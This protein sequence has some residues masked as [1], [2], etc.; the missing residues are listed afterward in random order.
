MILWYNRAE[1]V[2]FSSYLP[3]PNATLFVVTRPL[4]YDGIGT[5]DQIERAIASMTADGAYDV[6]GV[7]QTVADRQPE[8]FRLGQLPCR[9]R[10]HYSVRP[11][12]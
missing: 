9:A 12:S 4:V 11:A 3:S 10:W 6:E 7:Y 8:A 5:G 1:R 2:R